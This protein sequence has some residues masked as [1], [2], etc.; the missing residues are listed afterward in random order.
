[1]SKPLELEKLEGC[2]G[3]RPLNKFAP[4]PNREIPN[5]PKH[6]GKIAKRKYS[7]LVRE[8]GPAGMRVLGASDKDALAAICNIYE[9]LRK[10]RETLDMYGEYIREFEDIQHE[11]G[12]VESVL[13]K[14]TRRPVVIDEQKY[15]ALYMSGLIQFGL[16]PSARKNVLAMPDDKPE[17]TREE[18]IA[19]QRAKALAAAKDKKHV[20]AVN[21]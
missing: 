17:Q 19:G 9:R 3:H 16:T 8:I 21:G 15:H 13:I 4:E 11:D 18:R 2:P 20:K 1:M 12:T 10:C 14:E 7:D 5:P 6:L